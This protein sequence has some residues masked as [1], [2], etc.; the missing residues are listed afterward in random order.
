[1][2]CVPRRFSPAASLSA[3]LLSVLLAAT[4]LN[5]SHAQQAPAAPQP[6]AA[7]APEQA[8]LKAEE[9]DQLVAPIALYPDALLANVLMASTYPLEVVQAARWA[10]SNSKLKGDQ[11]KAAVDKQSWDESIKSL[12]ATASVLDMMSTQLDWTQK[13][14]DTVL[15][16]QADVMDA[17]QRLRGKAQAQK[18]LTTTKQQ[19]VTTKTE[20]NKQVIVIEP[21]EPNTI[22]VP[23]YDPGVVYGAWPYASYP[24]YYFTPPGYIA[25]TAIATGLAFG[26]GVAVGAWA[27][28][29][30][31]WGGGCGWGN[32]NIYVN[33][34]T[35]INANVNNWTHNSAHRHGV[36]YNNA[37][38]QQRFGNNNARAGAQQRMDFRGHDG[39]QVLNPDRPGAGDRKPG[40]GDRAGLDRPGGGDRKPGAGNRPGGGDRKPG[41]GNRPG[42][43]D[44]KPGAGNRPGGGAR[45]HAMS[46]IGQ[47]RS[48]VTHADRGRASM[49]AGPAGGRGGGAGFHGGGRG[50]GGFHGGGGRGGG[51]RSDIRL[52]HDIMLI[53]HLDS[54]LGFYR[55]AYNG[56]DQAYIG[57]MAQEVRRVV[58]GAVMRGADGYLR[59]NYEK[60]GVT[61]QTY[62]QWMRSGGRIPGVAAAGAAR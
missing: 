29:G 10:K 18:K 2:S 3:G 53:G 17:V 4:A 57:V 21:A 16:Q 11:L 28:G 24:P 22:Y 54:G 12:T 45:D 33:R 61:F 23:Y 30:R 31:Y 1:M 34:S 32:N 48:A 27:S 40:G 55:F 42:G 9:L 38:V 49:G 14:G 6:A 50:G 5:Q 59:V 41:A 35:N 15:A 19:T 26:A 43:G 46:N 58:P 52:K 62:E 7:T 44:R 36:K 25:G 20:N 47:G 37:S 39:R 51:R 8:P 13:L 56:S 60:V